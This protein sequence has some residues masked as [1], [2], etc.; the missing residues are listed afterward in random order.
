MRDLANH[1]FTVRTGWKDSPYGIH[2]RSI[3]FSVPGC[4]RQGPGIILS[5]SYQE[6]VVEITVEGSERW[7]SSS[8]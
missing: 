8:Y 7:S 1:R 5:F 3:F 2:H 6:A 4:K